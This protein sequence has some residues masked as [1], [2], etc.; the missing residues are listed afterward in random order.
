MKYAT[1]AVALYL[2]YRFLW[3]F[4]VS[5]MPDTTREEE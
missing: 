5:Y 3:A 1:G 4:L 2:F